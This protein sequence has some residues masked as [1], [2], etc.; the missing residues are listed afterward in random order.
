MNVLIIGG[1]GLIGRA[2]TDELVNNGHTVTIL[3]RKPIEPQMATNILWNHW[4]GKTVETL[5]P[6]LV[7]QDVVVNLAGES[8]GKGAWTEKRK[9]VLRESRIQPAQALV[10]AWSASTSKPSLLIQAS[11]VGFYGI[12]DQPCDETSKHGDDF[13]SHLTLDWEAA[14]KD[15]EG[16][17]ARRVVIRTGVVLAKEEGVLPQLMLPFRLFVGGPVGSS[18]QWISWIH[19]EDETRAIRFLIEHQDCKGTY[20]LTA[21]N[22]VTNQEIGKTLSKVIHRPYWFPVPALALKLVLGEMSTLVLDGQN[23]TPAR[24]LSEGFEFKYRKIET[25]LESLLS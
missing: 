9:E 20:N 25:A 18:N 11:A 6:L 16:L 12:G 14:S 24:L 5:Q 1:S 22:P 7:G 2:L 8:I 3:T 15:V 21:P 17:G 13:L 19:L 10:N 4:D 23:V